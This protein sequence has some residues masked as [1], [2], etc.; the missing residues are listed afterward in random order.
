M[1]RWSFFRM[2]RRSI[3]SS[4]VALFFIAL[5]SIS[6]LLALDEGEVAPVY[7]APDA[8][9]AF[10]DEASYSSGEL[11][12]NANYPHLAEV[13]GIAGTVK[14]RVCIDSTGAMVRYLIEQ[15]VHPSLDSAAVFAVKTTKFEA[16]LLNK[17]P[18]CMWID[19]P[20]K[21]SGPDHPSKINAAYDERDL[22]E[23][24]GRKVESESK[25]VMSFRCTINKNG[26]L[27][28]VELTR[29]TCVPTNYPELVEQAIRA[30]AFFPAYRD[31]DPVESE[32]DVTIRFPI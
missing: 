24:L 2:Y 5:G 10:S 18:I 7:P 14:L 3:V 27:K 13:H 19:V 15:G 28:K 4:L 16:G 1:S 9:V 30:T 6:Q 11:S 26:F 12:D 32:V 20:V 31:G 23:R 8:K 22:L 29:N 17:K 21:F 25:C